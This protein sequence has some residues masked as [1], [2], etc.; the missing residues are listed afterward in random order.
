MIMIEK[1]KKNKIILLALL[2]TF[3]QLTGYFISTKYQT[4]VHTSSF[5]LCFKDA[6]GW[7]YALIGIFAFAV[8]YLIFSR[9]FSRLTQNKPLEEYGAGYRTLLFAPALFLT[10]L[11]VL[12]A[13]YPG[14]FN[15]D[16]VG[17][18]PQ[19]L[20]SD[21]PYSTHHPLFHTLILGN[22]MK[23]GYLI[24]GGNLRVGL[25]FYSLFQMG[26]CA[27]VFSLT[28][29]FIWKISHKKYLIVLAFIYYAL[30]PVI[31]L[32]ALSTT[33]DVLFSLALLLCLIQIYELYQD[34][35]T[36]WNAKYKAILLMI[37]FLS[38][39]LLRNNG[40]YVVLLLAVGT[41]LFSKKSRRKNM[42]LYG[43]T[44][45]LYLIVSNGL[46]FILHAESGSKAE[47]FSIPIQQLARVYCKY[48]EDAFSEE[49]LT[50]LYQAATP[51]TLTN[52]NPVLAD[53]VKNYLYFDAVWANKGDF[54]LLWLKTG[55]R[56][57]GSYIMAF[58]DITYQAWYPWTS[59]VDNVYT[60]HIYYF[61][62]EM[63]GGYLKQ[64]PYFEW[65]Y[66][67]Y[68]KIASQYSYQKFPVIRLF[69]SIGAMF[70]TALIT[71]FW[72]IYTKNRGVVWALLLVFMYCL[73]AMLGPVSL[74]RYYLILFYGLPVYIA[75][76]SGV[77]AS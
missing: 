43:C 4:S 39:C 36:F 72:G 70:W 30:F 33:K 46:V 31:A 15:Y 64:T 23:A 17:Q 20:Y 63:R 3:L 27:V 6:A 40:I 9:L 73:T 19:V 62:Y 24:S 68:I 2:I 8:W 14:F 18:L 66:Q 5:F 56:Y 7:Q 44:I 52:Y 67:Q 54:L 32:F 16:A 60:G 35:D 1:E 10:W 50:L 42:L 28:I 12:F 77:R 37:T 53:Y 58:L 57:P 48:G 55:L 41:L 71:W 34:P 51:E 49:E 61:D 75:F 26:V 11:P 21:V 59:I 29:R 65:L 69:F 13:C 74:V 76:L 25:L 22:I 47:A 45:I 38:M